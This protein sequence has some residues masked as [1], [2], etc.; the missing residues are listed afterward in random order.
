MGVESGSDDTKRL[1]FNRPVDNEAV[2]KA[3]AAIR[4]NPRIIAYYFFII[5]NPYEERRD[6]LGTIGLLKRLPPPFFLRAYNLIF[7]PGTPS[8]SA[9][10]AGTGSYLESRTAATSSIL[11]R[12]WLPR[13][14]TGRR[15]TSTSMCSSLSCLGSRLASE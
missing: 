3:A 10:L 1:V 5:G 8:F 15:I 13:A 12:A 14:T 2:M 6:L 7:I 11:R 9:V 4:K